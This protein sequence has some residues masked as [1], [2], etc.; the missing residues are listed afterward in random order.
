MTIAQGQARRA[1]SSRQKETVILFS[2]AGNTFAIAT[3]AVEEIRE[4]AG[5]QEFPSRLS[6]VTRKLVRQ[7]RQYL[8]VDAGKHFRLSNAQPT[9]LMVLRDF[10]IAVMVDSIHRM[11]EIQSI[12]TLPEDFSG[13]ERNWY[14][15]LTLLKGKVIPVIR[16][17]T[18]LSRAEITLL[19]AALRGNEAAKPMAVTA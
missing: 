10:P 15:G 14:R 18:F 8:V 6:K 16:S 4:L 3:S 12:Q 2:I 19:S 7:G 13:E 1:S 9:R 5:L 17:E 11:Q